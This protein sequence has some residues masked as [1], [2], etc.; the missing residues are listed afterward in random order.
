MFLVGQKVKLVTRW[1]QNDSV[2]C[3]GVVE[4]VTRCYVTM[5]NQ[6]GNACKFHAD[7]RAIG[8][9]SIFNNARLV[10]Y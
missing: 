5:R 9:C 6:H 10:A 3:V 7:G 8:F 2:T 4:R 1:Q